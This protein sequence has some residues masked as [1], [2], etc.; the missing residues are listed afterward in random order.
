MA[1]LVSWAIL[2]SS[3]RLANYA[4]GMVVGKMGTAIVSPEELTHVIQEKG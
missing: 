2:T 1:I 3:L 4:A